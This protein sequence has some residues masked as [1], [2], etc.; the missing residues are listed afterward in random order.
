MNERYVLFCFLIIIN[1]FQASFLFLHL[2][3]M[4]SFIFKSFVS[5]FSLIIDKNSF[6]QNMFPLKCSDHH[7]DVYSKDR[8]DSIGGSNSQNLDI[9]KFSSK[10]I[11]S[12]MI[13]LHSNGNF[14]HGSLKWLSEIYHLLKKFQSKNLLL[15]RKIVSMV[16]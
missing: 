15:I 6:K 10:N 9:H 13:C 11:I 14:K 4:V 5:Y 1:F 8:K 12:Q 2:F 7:S 16:P 3:T